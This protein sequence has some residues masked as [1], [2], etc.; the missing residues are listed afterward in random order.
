MKRSLSFGRHDSFVIRHSS[1][2]LVELI[3]VVTIILILSGLVFTAAG[4]VQKKAGRSRAEAEMIAL[5][6]AIEAYK[7]DNGSYPRDLGTGTPPK[8]STDGLDAA[9]NNPQVRDPST[10]DYQDASRFLYGQLS[11]DYDPNV[12]CSG[13]S[14]C[15]NYNYVIDTDNEKANRVYFNFPPSMLSISTIYGNGNAPKGKPSPTPAEVDYKVNFIRDPFGYPYGYSTAHQAWMEKGTGNPEGY[16]PTYDLWS[17]GGTICSDC[18][19]KPTEKCC[20]V[21]KSEAQSTWITNW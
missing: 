3:V 15:T 19:G 11:G 7:N 10:D 2:T 20:T 17:T 21:A 18:S 14:N 8:S 16:N 4:Y 1:F 5:A 9:D 12:S 6:S 13:N